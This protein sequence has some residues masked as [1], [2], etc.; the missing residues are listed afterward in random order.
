VRVKDRDAVLAKLR[1]RG[2]GAAVHYRTD[3]FGR[4]DGWTQS[5]LSLPM[6]P[7]MTDAQVSRVVDAVKAS[8]S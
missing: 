2:I 8:V 5:N 3:A 1:E 7:Q 6:Y 4:E